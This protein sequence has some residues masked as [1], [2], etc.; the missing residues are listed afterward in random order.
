MLDEGE[1]WV[2]LSYCEYSKARPHVQTK[3]DIFEN[4]EQWTYSKNVP[5]LLLGG[6]GGGV[7]FPG[8]SF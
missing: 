5:L 7:L 8:F 2:G 3:L 6:D 4:F 1:S